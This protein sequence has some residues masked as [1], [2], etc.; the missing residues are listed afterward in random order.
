MTDTMT[1]LSLKCS[2][3]IAAPVERVFD[4]WLDAGMLAHDD[5]QQGERRDDH[6]PRSH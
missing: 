1:D 6:M 4:A 2:R 5:R 3:T